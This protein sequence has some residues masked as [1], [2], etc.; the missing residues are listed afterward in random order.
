MAAPLHHTAQAAV[1]RRLAE[2][3]GWIGRADLAAGLQW[4]EQ[5]VDDELADLVVAGS[6]LYN[7]RAREYRLG[8]S[9]LARSAMQRLL[10]GTQKQVLLARPHKTEPTML[11]GLAARAVD[12]SGGELLV[13]GDLEMPYDATRPGDVDALC[14]AI[15]NFDRGVARLASES[16]AAK[17]S[18]QTAGQGA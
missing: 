8:G 12:Y 15:A 2:A 17:A 3:A 13:M 1:L 16:E 14:Q 7:A 9:P 11:M 10:A 5:R 4:S 6:A 18:T